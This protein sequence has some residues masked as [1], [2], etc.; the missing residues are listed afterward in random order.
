[1]IWITVAAIRKSSRLNSLAVGRDEI[2]EAVEEHPFR[3][4]PVIWVI[5]IASL[6]IAFVIVYY[7]SGASFV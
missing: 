2:P 3:L 1:M 7:A 4:N 5:F 6:F